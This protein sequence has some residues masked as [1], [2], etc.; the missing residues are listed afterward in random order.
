MEDKRTSKKSMRRVIYPVI[1]VL[2]VLAAVYALGVFD[3][4]RGESDNVLEIDGMQFTGRLADGR[5]SG[6]GKI[7]FENGDTFE[8]TLVNGQ[9]SGRGVY[10]F[11]DGRRVEGEFEKG[12]LVE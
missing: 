6:P 2:L 4:L 10:T 9:F 5:F 8:G 1:I 3:A 11:S 12:I 7:F